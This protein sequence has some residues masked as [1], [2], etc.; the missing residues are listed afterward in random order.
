[1]PRQL[2]LDTPGALHHVME[3]GIEGGKI[4][5]GDR[6]DFLSRLGDLCRKRSLVIYGWTL[7]ENHFHLLV[8]RGLQSLSK[9]MR[10]LL[11][12]YVINFNLRYRRHGHLFQNRHKSIVFEEDPYLLELTRYIH[13]N[14]IRAGVVENIAAL[15]KYP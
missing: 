7:M 6:E 15:A 9:S 11:T 10:K 3:R 12:G 8:G 5:R 13:L 2:R 4:F 14:P 1:V